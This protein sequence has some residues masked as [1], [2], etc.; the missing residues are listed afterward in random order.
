MEH[1]KLST[2]TMNQG[3]K[4]K[5]SIIDELFVNRSQNSIGNKIVLKN[6][7]SAFNLFKRILAFLVGSLIIYTLT[8]ACIQS[9]NE[10]LITEI[11]DFVFLAVFGFGFVF[12]AIFRNKI[13]K[14]CFIEFGKDRIVARIPAPVSS[15]QQDRT[16]VLQLMFS[17]EYIE[18]SYKYSD[19]KEI[20]IELTKIIIYRKNGPSQEID[21]S[22]FD[23]EKLKAIKTKFQDIQNT[24]L[25]NSQETS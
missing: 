9:P 12:Y 13:H 5:T 24:M 11:R 10:C 6:P 2:S 7:R 22:N 23:Y 19:I 21:L 8:M 1:A 4:K 18:F 14:E 17:P 16:F 3:A 15:Y 25:S 20:K